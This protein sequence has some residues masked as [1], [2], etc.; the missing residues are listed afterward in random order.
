MLES[1]IKLGRLL[2]Y[3]VTFLLGYSKGKDSANAK[4]DKETK[5]ISDIARRFKRL[6]K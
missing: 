5:R 4:I 2:S 3:P 1:I 6:R